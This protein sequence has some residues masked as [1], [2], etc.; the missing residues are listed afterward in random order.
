MCVRKPLVLFS[1][2]S[3]RRTSPPRRSRFMRHM[4]RSVFI[5]IIVAGE[6]E[7]GDRRDGGGVPVRVGPGHPHGGAGGHFHGGPAGAAGEGGGRA[8]EGRGGGP[9]GDG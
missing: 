5:A 1:Q 4:T 7:A 3:V 8:G 2:Y 6:P 9:G